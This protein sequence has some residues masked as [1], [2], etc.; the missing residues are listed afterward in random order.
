MTLDDPGSLVE[1]PIFVDDI[2]KNWGNK[3]I[4]A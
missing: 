2:T 1:G 4:I 3:N